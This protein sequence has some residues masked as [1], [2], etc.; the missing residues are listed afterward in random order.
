[1]KRPSSTHKRKKLKTSEEVGNGDQENSNDNYLEQLYNAL[2]DS[3]RLLYQ[4]QVE[5]SIPTSSSAANIPKEP[6]SGELLKADSL[7]ISSSSSLSYVPVIHPFHLPIPY[8]HVPHALFPS[9]I[10]SSGPSE[11][12]TEQPS[13]CP[14]NQPSAFPTAQP[15][16]LPT[17]QPSRAPSK[18]PT[19][20]PSIQPS[21]SP[22]EQPSMQ[23]SS[24]PS[25][26][27]S[28]V[29]SSPPSVQ[30][31]AQPSRKPSTQPSSQP[32]DRPTSQP[33]S[34]PTRQPSVQPTTPPTDHPSSSPTHQPSSQPSSH[35]HSFPTF[36]PS[37]QPVARPTENPFS[38]PSTR[39][40]AQPSSFPSSLPSSFVSFPSSVPSSQP[41][42]FPSKKPS[43]QPSSR[44]STVPTT[45]PTAQ[46]FSIPTAAPLVTIHQTKGLI[47]FLGNEIYPSDNSEVLGTSYILF[48][49]N[50]KHNAKFPFEIPLHS[51]HSRGYV[52]LL[53]KSQGGIRNAI[54]TKSTTVIGDINGDKDLDVL[55]GYP[56]E[57]KCSLFLGIG[58]GLLEESPSLTI[59]GD[60]THEGGQLGW[61]SFRIGDVNHDG[62]DEI[63]VSAVYANIVYLIY[64]KQK[65]TTDTVH[66]HELGTHEACKIVGSVSDKYF[67]IALALVH[68]FNND[69]T[70]EIAISAM[71]SGDG[72]GLVYILLGGVGLENGGVIHID[73]LISSNS[74][75]LLR[76]I[77]P[78]KSYTGFSLAG[79][80][81][82][83]RDNFDDLAIG[84]VSHNNDDQVV[85]IIYG[86]SNVYQNNELHLSKMTEEDG[87]IIRGA[88]FLVQAAGDLNSDGIPDVMITHFNQWRSH[89]H[90][91]LI[92]F[93]T[94]ATYSP[95]F[96]PT[97][98]PSTLPSSIPSVSPSS[99]LPTS[100]P[101]LMQI[102]LFPSSSSNFS[103]KLPSSVKPTRVPSFRP[104]R[105]SSPSP[106]ATVV[107]SRKPSAKP[108]FIRVPPSYKPVVTT[109]PT[110]IHLRSRYPTTSPTTETTIDSTGY[111]DILCTKAGYY[112]G[113]SES[114]YRFIITANNG[115]VQLTGAGRGGARNLYVLYCPTDRVVVVVKDFRLSTDMISFTHLSDAGYFY[116][117]L[118][119]LSYS[120]RKG[121][122]TLLFCS[123]NRLE[124]ILPSHVSFDLQDSNFLFT[125]PEQEVSKHSSNNSV[126]AQTQ[127]GVVAVVV[128]LVLI[129]CAITSRNN[130]EEK[131]KLKHEELLFSPMG[132]QSDCDQTDYGKIQNGDEKS[133]SKNL[134]LVVSFHDEPMDAN[135][136]SIG[137]SSSG[138]S[139]S[140]VSDEFASFRESGSQYQSS[141]EI[142]HIS[143][144]VF[145][146]YN[147]DDL[148]D[149]DTSSSIDERQN[150]R[151][152][153]D[154]DDHRQIE[155]QFISSSSTDSSISSEG[156]QVSRGSSSS[157]DSSISSDG[158]Q[159]SSSSSS[160]DSSISSEGSQVSSSSS[161]PSSSISSEGSQV[162]RGS[163]LSADSS[164]SSEGSQVSRGSSSSPSS[165]NSSEGS[166][167]SRGSSLSADSSI[168][169]EGSQ[170]SRGS[171][172]STSSSNSSEGSQVSRGSS[173]SADSS[174]S[175][176][177][178]QVSRGSPL[179]TSSSN[180]SEGSQVS[181][182]MTA[183]EYDPEEVDD[184]GCA[185][186]RCRNVCQDA[187]A[188]SDTDDSE[189]QLK[190]QPISW[191]AFSEGSLLQEIFEYA[192]PP[193]SLSPNEEGF[194]ISFESM[195]KDSSNGDVD[196][197]S[198]VNTDEWQDIL[199]ASD[200]EEQ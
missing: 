98:F 169:S 156:S 33:S 107:P 168:S 29:P 188:T 72:N 93:P 37:T 99:S 135:N 64:G 113:K 118:N 114:N 92:D 166:Q 142:S 110:N 83:N 62:L 152:H 73:Q 189:E 40:S 103:S 116:P 172:L 130:Q 13:S 53:Q 193:T 119:D 58:Q 121:P 28:R 46:P 174:I 187:I 191:V 54:S 65:F 192:Q 79:I 165:S 70:K 44:P 18:L 38:F 12:P 36:R 49:K 50:Y 109:P 186:S 127:I 134:T 199:L 150:F 120:S 159:V 60:L 52:S 104:S 67:G 138:V 68:D 126:L 51:P 170:V 63:F 10:P 141:S 91:Y 131:E 27:P 115:T 31:T 97:S 125:S 132:I 151:A 25:S 112:Q 7:V 80:G 194:Q 2:P 15:T 19:T 61:A 21:S 86:N 85:Y 146:N 42:S 9:S 47:T 84:S 161:P 95:T 41:T 163:S 34:Q 71:K 164:I 167:V 158:S 56:M 129:I 195:G 87:F 178:S 176:E 3:S 69:G 11:Q 5:E 43:Q 96:H 148:E 177:G 77:G 128:F 82:I 32:S 90:A 157:A 147:H 89:G 4:S 198:S 185:D 48:G 57:S 6:E 136:S 22:T 124:L 78:A 94:N 102:G 162:S 108:T 171:S 76:V 81:D 140:S 190:G 39:P 45:T 122:L 101:S 145:E 88:G 75:H 181:F 184:N 24:A 175:S 153:F 59:L 197:I 183:I 35:P 180:S 149:D 23:P 123:E 179:S 182:E 14:T 200:D 16:S 143:Y 55:I 154:H 173:S 105:P 106:T 1:L 74:K 196:D 8:S 117:S 111:T 144:L 139:S 160:A 20:V 17:N 155:E 100:S 133:I 30:P 137:Q 26:Q 66:L